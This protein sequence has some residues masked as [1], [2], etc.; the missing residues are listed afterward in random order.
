MSKAS[1]IKPYLTLMP[2]DVRQ[3]KS[4]R[5][6][7]GNYLPPT[8]ISNLQAVSV[9]GK[10]KFYSFS[11]N[12]KISL[13]SIFERLKELAQLET[14]WDSYGAQAISSV[15]LVTAFEV[16]EAVKERLSTKVK[17]PLPQFISPLADGGLQLEWSGKEGNMKVEIYPDG[18][19]GYVLIEGQGTTRKF[20]EKHQ[21]SLDEALNLLSQFFS[22]SLEL[23]EFQRTPTNANIPQGKEWPLVFL[24]RLL[25]LLKMILKKAD[26]ISQNSNYPKTL[27]LKMLINSP[28]SP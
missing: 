13:T 26:R 1:G 6:S 19:L 16:L 21:F 7:S 24:R 15:A 8:Q 18:D 20:Q 25:V 22:L 2:A 12:P 14:D 17:E 3:K 9:S 28:D 10:T 23:K 27:F 4:R 5:V 11:P